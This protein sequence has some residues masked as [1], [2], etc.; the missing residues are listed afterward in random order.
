[1]SATDPVVLKTAVLGLLREQRNLDV[2]DGSPDDTGQPSVRLDPDG[3]AHMYA[4]VYFGVG[5][6]QAASESLCGARDLDTLTFQVTAAGGDQDR[7]LRAA[8]KVRNALTNTY[9][10]PTSG[11]CREQLDFVVAQRDN[12][13]S[14]ARWFVPMPY[15]VDIP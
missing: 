7:A 2:F 5:A 13:A 6:A 11:R 9:L 1:M 4:A 8:Q 3:R 14:P 10:T 12:S 15:S